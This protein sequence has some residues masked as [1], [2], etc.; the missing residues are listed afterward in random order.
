MTTVDK[1]KSLISAISKR[2]IGHTELMRQGTNHYDRPFAIVANTMDSAKRLAGE[3]DL[4]T[5]VTISNIDHLIGS[6]LPVAID[7]YQVQQL[8]QSALIEISDRD[9]KLQRAMTIQEKMMTLVELYQKRA[10]EIES[11]S[12]DLLACNWW[13]VKKIISTERKLHKA[14][15]KYN[16]EYDGIAQ[17]FDTLTK[18]AK[19]THETTNS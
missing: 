15:L 10:H 17:T 14:I 4:A 5:P 6:D 16:T 12:S 8:L 2:G 3:S 19:H 13:D 7:H 11:I 1:I 18:I 9:F